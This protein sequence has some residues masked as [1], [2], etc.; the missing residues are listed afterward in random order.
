MLHPK[1]I[2]RDIR[3]FHARCEKIC[4][5]QRNVPFLSKIELTDSLFLRYQKYSKVVIFSV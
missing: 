4:Y 1:K 5:F 3:L 2:D